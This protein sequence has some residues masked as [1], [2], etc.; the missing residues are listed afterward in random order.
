[1]VLLVRVLSSLMLTF[2]RSVAISHF[3]SFFV[4][5]VT[6]FSVL[7]VMSL[8]ACRMI[9]EVNDKKET[10]AKEVAVNFRTKT[11]SI[12]NVRPDILAEIHKF[13]FPVQKLIAEEAHAVSK[14]LQEGKEVPDLMIAECN[15]RFFNQYML[16]CHHIL[17]KQL[18]S[19]IN[20]LMPEMWRGFQETFEEN[21]LEVYQ[22]RGLVDVAQYQVEVEKVAEK[23]RLSMNELFERARD[24]YYGLVDRGNMEEVAKFVERLGSVLEPVLE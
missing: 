8:G 17:H 15:C 14:R 9:L 7:F 4:S 16:S 5:F 2:Y 24:Q 22:S 20:I 6:S 10:N 19:N 23:N 18:C 21:G 13:P 12:A 1:M 11:I 3:K